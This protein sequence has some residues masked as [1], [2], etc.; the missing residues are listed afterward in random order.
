VKPLRAKPQTNGH[1]FMTAIAAEPIARRLGLSAHPPGLAGLYFTELWERFSFYGMRALLLL[2]MVTPVAAGG[3]GFATPAAASIYGTYT[4][5]VYLLAVPG[6]FIADRILGAKRSVLFGGTA[7]AAGHYALAVPS[8]FSFYAGLALI[9]LGTGLFKPNISALVGALYTRDDVRRDAGFS[10]FYMGINV[11][12]FFA[13]L[14]TG[15]L[16]QST[17][18]K[19]W[20][21]AAG[22]N[23]ELSWHWGFGAAGVGMTISM[24]FFA[25]NAATLSNPDAGLTTP[26]P[27]FLRDGLIVGFGTVALFGVAVLSD[28]DG[29]NW[30][31][32]LYLLLPLAAVAYGAAQLREDARRL[33]AV[34]IYFIA[35]MI[36]W[37]VYEQAGTTLTLF[38]DTLTRNQ[39]VGLPFPSSWYQ[40]VNPVF[41]IMLTPVAA[42]LWL[43]LG[44]R[45][46]SSPVKFGLGLAFLAAA[47]LLMVPAAG[48]AADG[49]VSP[50]WLV[51]VYF[52]FTVG[53]L[54]LSPVG[55][56]TMTRIAPPRMTGFVLGLWF[57][58]AA[59]GNKLA[60]DIGGAFTAT[61]P[62]ALVLSFLAQAALVAVAAALMFAITPIVRRLSEG[63]S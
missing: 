16:A 42:T 7:I 14:I 35:A 23:P 13:P 40:S 31:R 20:L 21:A 51:G 5:A 2:F 57:L 50:L 52:L 38:A 27:A 47:F 37:A 26:A 63:D 55:L 33:A 58:A 56:S 9:A 11:G 10:L 4:M 3:L 61:D 60:G 1:G 6:G 34:G 62:D 32:W 41:V 49:R 59:F 18:F 29:F 45:Q 8:V 19:G 25:R 24:L 36:F 17:L 39:F 48:Y 15:F 22:F 54:M 30:L 53:E 12:A 46:P 44:G 43:Q 28:M